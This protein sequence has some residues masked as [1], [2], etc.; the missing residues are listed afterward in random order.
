MWRK[1]VSVLSGV[2]V[3][4]CLA[5]LSCLAFLGSARGLAADDAGGILKDNGLTLS[6]NAYVLTGEK[7][8]LDDMKT[9]QK[10]KRKADTD[11]RIRKGY[12]AR[13]KSSKNLIEQ[14][15]KEYEHLNDRLALAR[16]VDAHNGIIMRMN[17]LAV[18]AKEA[19]ETQK[20]LQ[21]K[22]GKLGSDS[23]MKYVDDL[24]ALKTKADAVQKKYDELASDAAVKTAIEKAN[25]SAASPAKLGP[26]PAFASAMKDLTKW[27]A[28]VN[29]E[30]ITISE[31]GGVQT[32]EVRLNGEPHRMVLDNGSSFISLPAELAAQ[33]KMVPGPQDPTVKMR[34]ADGNLI[35]GRMMMLK[36]VRLGRFTV[37]NVA[38]VVLQSGL[39]DAP[40][41]LGNSFLSHF[42]VKIDQQAGKL[43][44][45]EVGDEKK[46]SVTN[47]HESDKD[48]NDKSAGEKP[49]AK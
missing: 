23:E 45:T 33:L 13:I 37:D 5:F 1:F 35:E 12:E 47:T 49:D 40:A 27:Q 25:A 24:A 46:I 21:D 44:L 43:Q 15:A 41:L 7:A 31:E 34:I 22:I 2:S 17:R 36:S 14:S 28:S 32:V 18:Q 3:V 38:C 4:G 30:A 11:T 48:E 42:V 9:L 6:G 29:S 26:S 19:V 20:D 16:T 8:V 10:T 39:H